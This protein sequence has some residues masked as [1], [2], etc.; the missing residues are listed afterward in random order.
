MTTILNFINDNPGFCIVVWITL[1]IWVFEYPRQ[2]K[3]RHN[4]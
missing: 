2:T 4:Q 3:N 1:T